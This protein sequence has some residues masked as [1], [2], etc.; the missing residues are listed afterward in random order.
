MESITGKDQN[1]EGIFFIRCRPQSSLHFG[2]TADGRPGEGSAMFNSDR[3]AGSHLDM[4]FVSCVTVPAF[5]IYPDHLHNNRIL[6]RPADWL[7]VPLYPTVYYKA[8]QLY[9]E[10]QASHRMAAT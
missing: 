9:L 2:G 3:P 10:A 7:P 6:I 8:G 1:G 5:L 4:L